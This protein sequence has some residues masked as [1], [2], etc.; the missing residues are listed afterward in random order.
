MTNLLTFVPA[1]NGFEWKSPADDRFGRYAIE[2]MLND[3]FHVWHL[4]PF[5]NMRDF[6]GNRPT[7]GRAI[8]LAQKHHTRAVLAA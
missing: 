5:N 4:S 8:E 6:L 3:T 2:L 1:P 7:K